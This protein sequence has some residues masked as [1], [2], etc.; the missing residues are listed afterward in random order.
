MSKGRASTAEIEKT[1]AST[2]D[3]A[4]QTAQRRRR[5]LLAREG[6]V[7]VAVAG[8]ILLVLAMMALLWQHWSSVREPT[9]AIVIHGDS[10]LDGAQITVESNDDPADPKVDVTLGQD[11]KFDPAIFR[12]PGQYKVTI[13]YPQKGGTASYVVTVDHRRGSIIDLPTTVTINAQPGDKVTLINSDGVSQTA[14]FD[15]RDTRATFLLMPG[16]Y[17]LVRTRG[18][19]PQPPQELVVEAHTPRQI[20]LPTME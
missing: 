12:Y 17:I 13:R 10:S 1:A 9:T 8:T 4:A 7:R 16:K 20:D 18:A 3:G 14:T 5:S 11:R 15:S 6:I 19:A 2:A